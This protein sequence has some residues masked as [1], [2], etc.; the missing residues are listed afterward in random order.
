MPQ[1]TS[2]L[3]LLDPNKVNKKLIPDT[4][5][6]KLPMNPSDKVVN[7]LIQLVLKKRL[8][9]INSKIPIKIHYYLRKKK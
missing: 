8:S 3:V 7:S 4:F 9:K 5:L 1:S 6:F 2:H